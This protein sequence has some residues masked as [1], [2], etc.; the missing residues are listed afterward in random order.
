MRAHPQYTV[1]T[2]RPG[3]TALDRAPMRQRLLIT[4][5]LLVPALAL[6]AGIGWSA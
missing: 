3:E 6:L 2:P 5:A 4:I 1:V